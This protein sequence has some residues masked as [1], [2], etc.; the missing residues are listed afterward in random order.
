MLQRC[1][2]ITYDQVENTFRSWMCDHYKLMSKLQRENMLTLYEELYNKMITIEYKGN[3]KKM[4]FTEG[5]PT[6]GEDRGHSNYKSR[7]RRVS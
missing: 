7:A 4:I 1:E 3:K 5:K 6:G 2:E